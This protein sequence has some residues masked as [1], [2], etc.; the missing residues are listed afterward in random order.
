MGGRST[1]AYPYG[2]QLK[3]DQ[4]IQQQSENAEIE[5]I[6]A[7]RDHQGMMGIGAGGT[8]SIHGLKRCACCN[9]FTIPIGSK[10]ETCS[11][12]G[13]IDDEY[14]NTHPKSLNGRNPISLEDARKA[15]RKIH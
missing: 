7:I 2:Q 6:M 10:N 11:I 8:P 9:R 3:L 14:Q 1:R 13:W 15:Y 12:C 4:Y 5:K